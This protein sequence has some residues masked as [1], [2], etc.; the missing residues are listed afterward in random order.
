MQL[1]LMA[2]GAYVGIIG[3]VWVISAVFEAGGAI[4]ILGL[5]VLCIFALWI[6]SVI[7]DGE[8]DGRKGGGK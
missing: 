3:V 8:G 1:L 5:V 4:G 6:A 7:Y 2:A